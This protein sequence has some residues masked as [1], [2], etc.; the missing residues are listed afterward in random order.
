MSGNHGLGLEPLPAKVLENCQRTGRVIIISELEKRV[1]KEKKDKMELH[2]I[3]S[4]FLPKQVDEESGSF[5]D[6]KKYYKSLNY[7][8]VRIGHKQFIK[9]ILNNPVFHKPLTEIFE[10]D[11]LYGSDKARKNERSPISF[12]QRKA[13]L[14]KVLLDYKIKFQGLSQ[15]PECCNESS[16]ILESCH[17]LE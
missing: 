9:K 12:E 11:S 7:S 8:R 4:E 2:K 5:Y 17:I 16:T 10:S 15:R 14:E 3:L 1:N 13:I 6:G